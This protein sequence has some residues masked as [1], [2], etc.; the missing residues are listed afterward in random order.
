[1]TQ[2]K[3]LQNQ[4]QRRIFVLR[5][6]SVMLSSDL[7]HL[8]GVETK[9]LNQAVKRNLDRFPQD[10]MFQLTSKEYDL[11]LKS[12]I[13]TSSWGGSRRA[14]P[15]A[16]TEHGV[17]MLSNILRS[18]TAIQVSIEIIRAF[19]RLRMIVQ[20]NEEMARELLRMER[21]YDGQFLIVF[22][23]LKQLLNRRSKV[24]KQIGF[25]PN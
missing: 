11:I 2:Q 21:R 1:M 13:V 20:S 16:F 23:A 3:F 6:T 22:R 4:I 10:F 5:D 14:L 8:Y 12:Q 19:V 7:A 18:S 17:L 15:Y 24:T 25:R 9:V